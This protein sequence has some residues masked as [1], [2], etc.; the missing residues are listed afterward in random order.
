LGINDLNR[1]FVCESSAQGNAGYIYAKR[2][3][4]EN[5][6]LGVVRYD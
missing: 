2:R 4:H 5:D 6:A 3:S 1:S